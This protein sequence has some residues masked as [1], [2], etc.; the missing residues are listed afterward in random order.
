MGTKSLPTAELELCGTPGRLVGQLGR[1]VA[2][3]ATLLNLTR[4]YTASSSVATMRYPLPLPVT[5]FINNCILPLKIG[6]RSLSL[7]T[8]RIG[9]VRL[10][11][12]S[13]SCLST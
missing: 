4:I 5:I 1:G 12:S 13:P 11:T 9:G 7:A 8:T 3:V 2:T 6:R 10:G